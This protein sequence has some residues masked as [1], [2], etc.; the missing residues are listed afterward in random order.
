[1]ANEYTIN[2]SLDVASNSTLTNPVD[3]SHP[4]SFTIIN[5]DGVGG[6]SIKVVADGT[7]Y[8]EISFSGLS[9]IQYL[10]VSTDHP[11]KL[12]LNGTGASGITAIPI[13]SMY[14]DTFGNSNNDG[15]VKVISAYLRN[16]GT[17]KATCKV[18]YSGK[19]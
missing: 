2:C 16:D 17:T 19:E 1:M 18:R 6:D 14:L 11:V 8:M 15:K 3:I 10:E 7:T 9:Y 5:Q 13:H 4:E 12:F